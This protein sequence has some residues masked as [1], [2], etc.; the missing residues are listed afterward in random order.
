MDTR[1]ADSRRGTSR[2][3]SFRRGESVREA[4]FVAPYAS[5]VHDWAVTSRHLVFPLMPTTADAERMR[6]GGPHWVF[7]PDRDAAIGILPRDAE[8]ADPRWYRAPPCGVGHIV[9]AFSE[10]ERVYVDIFV[11][12]RNQ[13]PFIAS[14]DGQPF[15]REKS[16]PRLTRWTFD[17]ASAGGRF[18]SRTLY[19]DFME[20][21]AIDPRYQMHPYRHGY[22]TVIDPAKPLN[23]AGTVGVGWNTLVHIDVATGQLDRYYVGERTTCQ[24][25][26][27]VPRSPA[28]PE[29]EGFI[30]SQLT[31]FEGHLRT[32]IIVLDAQH[33]AEGPIATIRVPFRLRAAVH[34]NWVSGSALD[35]ARA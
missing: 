24:E 5:M 18:E 31:R 27:F 1:R 17:L 28:A 9:N 12:E 21:P 11:S 15:D 13:F 2:C 19:G 30:L 22:C 26:C 33:L 6:R 3:S 10:G 8:A 35:A 34:G 23:V 29:G 7:E 20:M 16:T 25:P 32:E 14:T 4:F